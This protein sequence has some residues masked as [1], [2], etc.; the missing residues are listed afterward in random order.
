[1]QLLGP[2]ARSVKCKKKRGT[3]GAFS[4]NETIHGLLS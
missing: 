1:V 2:A 4:F 3:V